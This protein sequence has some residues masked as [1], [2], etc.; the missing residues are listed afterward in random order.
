MVIMRENYLG[1]VLPF[2]LCKFSIKS[3]LLYFSE[4]RYFNMVPIR[5]DYGKGEKI[6]QF[7]VNSY[8]ENLLENIDERLKENLKLALS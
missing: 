7:K 3:Y 4:D 5:M 8:E 6:N 1:K 2:F